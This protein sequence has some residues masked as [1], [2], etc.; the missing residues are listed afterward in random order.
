M[1]NARLLIS[2]KSSLARPSRRKDIM[3]KPLLAIAIF[4]ISTMAQA[5]PFLQVAENDQ[6]TAPP[7]VITTEPAEPAQPA[8]PKSVEAPKSVEPAQAVAQPAKA[9]EPAAE[10]KPAQLQKTK[11][12]TAHRE[13]AE[14]KARRIAAKFG[15]YW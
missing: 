4:S 7:A 14:E 11:S 6:P 5:A 9:A 12:R 8:Q 10:T 3:R 1:T 2:S 13:S 15:V